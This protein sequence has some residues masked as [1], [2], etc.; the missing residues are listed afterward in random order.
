MLAQG[1]PQVQRFRAD[2]LRDHV[3]AV[4]P[5]HMVPATIMRHGG[6][7]L[8]ANGKVDRNRL[9]RPPATGQRGSRDGDQLDTRTEHALAALWR[10][11]LR[12][13]TVTPADNLFSLGGDSLI[14]TKL[15][16]RIHAEFGVALTLRKIFEARNLAELAT[17]VAD[18]VTAGKGIPQ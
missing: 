16:S 7:P 8:T 2:R 13:D 11:L 12:I 1:P 15:A 18:G 3:A 5:M 6:L 4:L 14:A 17:V 9:P 10:D